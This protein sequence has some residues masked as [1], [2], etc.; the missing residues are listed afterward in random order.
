MKE[1][2]CILRIRVY[3]TTLWIIEMRVNGETFQFDRENHFNAAPLP[4]HIMS[5]RAG[6]VPTASFSPLQ[7]FVKRFYYI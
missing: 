4:P 5:T 7:Y 2:E 3:F 6:A 1:M